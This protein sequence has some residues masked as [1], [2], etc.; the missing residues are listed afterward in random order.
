LWV[1]DLF[2]APSWHDEGKAL[3]HQFA[4]R[5]RLKGIEGPVDLNVYLDS[6]AEFELLLAD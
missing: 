2:G 5:G 1:R 6:R 4:N 3:F